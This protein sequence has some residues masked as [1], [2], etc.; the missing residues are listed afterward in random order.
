MTH[1]IQ[2][3]VD[4]VDEVPEEL[5]DMLL[6]SFLAKALA[7]GYDVVNKPQLMLSNWRITCEVV[8]IDPN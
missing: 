2:L 1:M 7:Q 6:D 4:S 5:Y 3:D 8:D